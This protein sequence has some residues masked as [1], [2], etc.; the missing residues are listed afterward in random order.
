MLLIAPLRST[1]LRLSPST[2]QIL[3]FTERKIRD[4]AMTRKNATSAAS[5]SG[6]D[7]VAFMYTLI[8]TAKR[9]DFFAQAW[10][11]IAL[12][13]FPNFPATRLPDLFP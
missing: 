5:E 11:A 4:V 10:L 6:D 8:G 12:T 2:R 9:R 3:T 7:S 1:D 13:C